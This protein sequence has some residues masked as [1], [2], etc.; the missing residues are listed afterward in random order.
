MESRYGFV[1]YVLINISFMIT[2]FWL[3]GGEWSALP[4]KKWLHGVA[5]WILVLCLYILVFYWGYYFCN[6]RPTELG[7]S[8]IGFHLEK[9]GFE[10]S[11][12][13]DII[14]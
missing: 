9:T 10:A 11:D 13:E 6:L 4:D 5:A 12:N 7:T 14:E 1:Y 3:L 2:M 8:K